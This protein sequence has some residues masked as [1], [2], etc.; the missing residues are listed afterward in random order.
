MFCIIDDYMDNQVLYRKYRPANFDQVLGQEHIVKVLKGALK[1][2][3]ISHAYLFSGSR[4]TGK[5]TVARIMAK[6]LGSSN[7]D[8]HEIDAASNRRIDDVRELREAV[9]TL[10][11]DSKYKVYIIDEVHMLTTEAFNALLKTLEEPPKHIVFILATT[12]IEKVP[13]TIISRC[14]TF[15]FKKPT[16]A[17]LKTFADDIAKKEG[18]ELTPD[19]AEL[20]SLLGDGSFRDTHGILQKIF[21]F[22]KGKKITREEIEEVTEAPPKALVNGFIEA[23]WKNDLKAGLGIIGDAV[24]QN[25]DFKVFTKL[26]IHKMRFIFLLRYASEFKK[27][28]EEHVG[29][30]D[31]KFLEKIAAEKSK[32][33]SSATLI[34]LLDAYQ[35]LKYSFV[36]SLP[37]ELAL[38]KILGQG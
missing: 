37:L 13:E 5:T 33:I 35:N 11:F 23:V 19:A 21:G 22:S 26:I 34:T 6:E 30:E 7:N 36:P 8:I 17:L 32:T 18:R 38:V 27:E 15:V 4:G 10:P 9:R 2:G 14:Q 20:V 25:T 28:I 12:D 29:I 16:E 3:N 24:K 1:L 31:A